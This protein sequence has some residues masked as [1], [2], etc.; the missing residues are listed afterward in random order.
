MKQLEQKPVLRVTPPLW[1]AGYAHM[2]A[3][4]PS[5]ARSLT[6]L[7]IYCPISSSE[8]VLVSQGE[9]YDLTYVIG[10]NRYHR[11]HG[12]AR[13]PVKD[14]RQGLVQRHERAT[15]S[16]SLGPTSTIEYRRPPGGEMNQL[17]V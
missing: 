7:F 6:N 8:L 12:A 2:R 17:T 11:P 4:V 15:F 10:P 13:P 1:G 3:C 5:P 14:Q 16:L 9:Q